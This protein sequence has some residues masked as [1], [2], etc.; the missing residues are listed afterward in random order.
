MNSILSHK[1]DI[2]YWE[3][4]AAMVDQCIDISLNLSQSGHPGGSRSKVPVLITAL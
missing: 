3:A 4:I 2:H 1:K